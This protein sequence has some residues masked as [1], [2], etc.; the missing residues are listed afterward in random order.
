[1]KGRQDIFVKSNARPEGRRYGYGWIVP[2]RK[3]VLDGLPYMGGG[4]AAVDGGLATVDVAGQVRADSVEE[5]CRWRK[6]RTKHFRG[7]NKR[8]HYFGLY[9]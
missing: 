7:R 3:V 2:I 8:F 1:M 4:A 6:E 5:Y 9:E